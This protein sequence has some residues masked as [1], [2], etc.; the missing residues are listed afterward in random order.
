MQAGNEIPE[1]IWRDVER[2]LERQR[3]YSDGNWINFLNRM[4][5]E[6]A[7]EAK[8]ADAPTL[9]PENCSI[10]TEVWRPAE[11]R[12]TAVLR[13]DRDR[14]V[15]EERPIFVRYKD[16]LLVIDGNN[17]VVNWAKERG[18]VPCEIIVLDYPLR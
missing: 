3:K 18:N 13:H 11:L 9:R 5:S 7:C 14:P 10:S 2:Q 4:F 12:A 6:R 8:I 16:K 17:R 1:E 15:T